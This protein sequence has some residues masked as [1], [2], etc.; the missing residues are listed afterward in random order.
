MAS[1][2]ALNTVIDRYMKLKDYSLKARYTPGFQASR[3]DLEL[4]LE[5]PYAIVKR[6][7][8]IQLRIFGI[9]E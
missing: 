8:E 7:I 5:E 6:T 1:W 4:L 9:D 3:E 2:P